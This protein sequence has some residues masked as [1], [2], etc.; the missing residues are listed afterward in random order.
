MP[1]LEMR[2]VKTDQYEVKQYYYWWRK[3]QSDIIIYICIFSEA[4]NF[5][6]SRT[7]T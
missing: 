6:I 2:K 1:N 4:E 7:L 3:Q 5:V